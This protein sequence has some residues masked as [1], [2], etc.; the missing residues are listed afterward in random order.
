MG[1]KSCPLENMSLISGCVP[2]KARWHIEG[3]ARSS[4]D[5][6]AVLPGLL[7]RLFFNVDDSIPG[8][9]CSRSVFKNVLRT[10]LKMLGQST[11][12]KVENGVSGTNRRSFVCGKQAKKA[13]TL[14][15]YI[16]FLSKCPS[17]GKFAP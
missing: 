12:Y 4:E 10:L 14:V 5:E 17:K 11:A 2:S 15:R 9:D 3:Y 7:N 6:M 8:I 16:F 1:A 13:R